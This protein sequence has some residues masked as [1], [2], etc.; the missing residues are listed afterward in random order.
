MDSNSADYAGKAVGTHDSG[1][2]SDGTNK[3]AGISL[4]GDIFTTKS[5]KP[6]AIDT[7][8]SVDG[9]LSTPTTT[10]AKYSRKDLDTQDIFWTC[11]L[12]E[13]QAM[14]DTQWASFGTAF[15]VPPAG[16]DSATKHIVRLE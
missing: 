14:S 15:Y 3:A 4:R 12:E 16:F 11:S 8:E 9:L 1:T 6:S 5:E 13:F 2:G 7:S 10:S